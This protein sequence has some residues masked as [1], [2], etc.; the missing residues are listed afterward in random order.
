MG[1]LTP[2]RDDR[3]DAIGPGKPEIHQGD[4]RTMMPEFFERL[5]AIA[6]LSNQQHVRLGSN[7]CT[8]TL[9]KNWMVLNA[10]NANRHRRSHG[11]HPLLL[12]NG[13]K[14]QS[15]SETT[16]HYAPVA[17]ENLIIRAEPDTV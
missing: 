6:R 10:Q 17:E 8:Q 9:A 3:I 7:D 11:N 15:Q 5:R 13:T 12:C 4:I 1:K 2:D 14:F 16:E